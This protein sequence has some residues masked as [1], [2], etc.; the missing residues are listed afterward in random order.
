M[1]IEFTID[2]TRDF[3]LFTGSGVLT[4]DDFF[5]VFDAYSK[6]GPTRLELYDFREVTESRLSGE[7]IRTLS[8]IGLSKSSERIPGSRTALVATSSDAYGLSRMY[9]LLGKLEGVVWDVEV[10]RTMDA[11]YASLGLTAPE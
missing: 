11:A 5:G 9:Q 3:T 2:R 1:P 4:V 6:A 8:M 7:G 10:H